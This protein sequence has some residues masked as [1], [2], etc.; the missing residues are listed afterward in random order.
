MASQHATETELRLAGLAAA[1]AVAHALLLSGCSQSGDGGDNAT[2]TTTTVSST[3]SYLDNRTTTTTRSTTTTTIHQA[4][5]VLTSND[6]AGND[7]GRLPAFYWMDCCEACSRTVACHAWTH[8]AR[9]ID[10]RTCYL[11]SACPALTRSDPGLTSGV[12][13]GRH[14][15]ARDG[16]ACD[17]SIYGFNP[18]SCDAAGDDGSCCF[19]CCCL[20]PPTTTT[21]TTTSGPCALQHGLECLN[22]DLW[23]THVESLDD[24][25]DLCRIEPT[26]TDFT[27][28][29]YSADGRPRC[30]LKTGC[31]GFG[32]CGGCTYGHVSRDPDDGA[33]TV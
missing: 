2:V 33:T 15:D 17:C 4:C 31:D 13:A 14:C 23:D 12:V 5:N 28:V 11:K 1:G 10:D 29:L 30:Y 21:T 26:C 3:T 6:C 32:D 24:C 16:C 25:C 8:D 18:G 22:G 9:D 7:V 27:F 19:A 20:A